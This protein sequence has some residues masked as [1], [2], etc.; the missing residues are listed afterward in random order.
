[1]RKFAELFDALDS[2]TKTNA[3][4]VALTTSFQETNQEDLLFSIA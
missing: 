1:M 2:A 3:N 4:V